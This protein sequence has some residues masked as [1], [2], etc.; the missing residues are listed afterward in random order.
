MR[1]LFTRVCERIE[2]DLGSFQ[3]GE[4]VICQQGTDAS[5]SVGIIQ[6][7]GPIPIERGGKTSNYSCLNDLDRK[8]SRSGT[9]SNQG[10]WIGK[11][12]EIKSF[13]LIFC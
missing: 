1:L 6:W 2:K 7:V 10:V 13:E 11:L 4:T 12:I 5:P 3:V 8:R 9:E